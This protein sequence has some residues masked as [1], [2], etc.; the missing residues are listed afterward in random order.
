[1]TGEGIWKVSAPRRRRATT[2]DKI[3]MVVATFLVGVFLVV[4]YACDKEPSHGTAP[5]AAREATA[6]HP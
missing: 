4:A 6:V 3:F 1:M 2:F 5:A